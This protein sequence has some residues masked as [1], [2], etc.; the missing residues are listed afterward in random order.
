MSPVLTADQA[1]E[2]AGAVR[3]AAISMRV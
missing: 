3:D 1:A 2:V